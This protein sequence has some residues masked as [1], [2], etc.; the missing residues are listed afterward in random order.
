MNVILI[1]ITAMPTLYALIQKEDTDAL[2]K[3]AT[4]VTVSHAL[5]LTNAPLV[6]TTATRTQNVQIITVPFHVTAILA[7]PVMVLFVKM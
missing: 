1:M 3:T 2:A 4:K 5:I 7:T 6:D